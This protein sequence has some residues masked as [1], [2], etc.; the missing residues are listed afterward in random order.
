MISGRGDGATDDGLAMGGRMVTRSP[1]RMKEARGWE[2]WWWSCRKD[3]KSGGS[4]SRDGQIGTP[5]DERSIWSDMAGPACVLGLIQVAPAAPGGGRYSSSLAHVRGPPHFPS[6][7]T[8]T[9]LV[10]GHVDGAAP[11]VIESHMAERGM[12][13]SDGIEEDFLDFNSGARVR[14]DLAQRQG[15]LLV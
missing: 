15:V 5:H 11:L 14:V 1:G 6:R 12:I 3:R 9:E 4:M 10:F 8:G 13:F 2:R 7:T